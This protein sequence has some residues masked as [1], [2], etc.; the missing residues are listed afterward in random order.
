VEHSGNGQNVHIKTL[1][2]LSDAIVTPTVINRESKTFTGCVYDRGGRLFR[3]AQRTNRNVE[4]SPAD[5]D[6]IGTT[7]AFEEISGSCIYLGHYTNHYGHF[8]L[9]TLARFWVFEMGMSYDKVV[10]QPFVHPVP[11]A[12]F[13]PAITCFECFSIKYDKLLVISKKSRF[14]HL[15]VPTMLV[16]INNEANEDQSLIYRKIL[17]HCRHHRNRSKSNPSRIYLS[18]KK[19]G[20]PRIANTSK[21]A[22]SI[23]KAWKSR[24]GLDRG[25]V[26]KGHIVNEDEIEKLF[27]S[28]GFA[29]IYPEQI[30]FEE[31]V[32]MCSK[33][34]VMA[35]FEGSAMH[36][37]VFMKEGSLVITIESLRGTNTRN[38]MICNSLSR[39]RSEFIRFEGKI[40]DETLKVGEFDTH[41]LR[42]QLEKLV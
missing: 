12:S 19:L 8:I 10:F 22:R 3:P 7:E 35:G 37:S 38:Q 32:L 36:N 21:F 5:P 28:F 9:E 42:R 4:W 14:E 29:V 2:R 17:E 23:R 25:I 41:H 34:D 20:M 40:V 16:E 11:K 24:K 33:A 39:V 27:I 6:S 26:R 13:S 30:P 18:R 31:Q 15:L 1:Y